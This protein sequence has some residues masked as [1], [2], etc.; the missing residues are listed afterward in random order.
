LPCL[1]IYVNDTDVISTP[2]GNK[3]E[4]DPPVFFINTLFIALPTPKEGADECV[5][6]TLPTLAF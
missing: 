5:R 1:D 6:T 3:T 2:D 4:A